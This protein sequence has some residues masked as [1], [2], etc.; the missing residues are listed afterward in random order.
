[1][2]AIAVISGIWPYAFFA[3]F[4]SYNPTTQ[5]WIDDQIGS[6]EM[7]FILE[8]TLESIFGLDCILKFFVEYIDETELKPQYIR[9][10]KKIAMRYIYSTFWLDFIPLIPF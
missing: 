7:I 9:D 10:H 5:E 2:T 6:H 4:R 1:V 3:A 8:V